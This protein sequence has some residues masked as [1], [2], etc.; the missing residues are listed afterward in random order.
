MYN[1][2]GVLFS[3]SKE[4]GKE[5]SRE[6]TPGTW[7]AKESWLLGLFEKRFR[8]VSKKIV[9]KDKEIEYSSSG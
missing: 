8:R 2:K 6:R 4:S 3:G 9:R 7:A 1:L 5:K